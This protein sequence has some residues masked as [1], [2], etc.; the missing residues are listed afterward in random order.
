MAIIATTPFEAA[1]ASQQQLHVPPE[2]RLFTA[3]DPAPTRFNR[4]GYLGTVH[5]YVNLIAQAEEVAVQRREAA[6]AGGY[7]VKQHR[8]SE[9][10]KGVA[11]ELFARLAYQSAA[12]RGL[13]TFSELISDRPDQRPDL[14]FGV[15]PGLA[16]LLEAQQ[17]DVKTSCERIACLQPTRPD[18]YFLVA[19]HDLD[20]YGPEV[21]GCL[22]VHIV[23]K[24]QAHLAYA[25]CE[26]IRENWTRYERGEHPTAK[27]Y[28]AYARPIAGV[29]PGSVR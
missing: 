27:K 12:E 4:G 7:A 3:D 9:E 24:F 22:F 18:N 1:A 2:L 5:T 29:L 15:P 6:I 17:V 25:S 14:H 8:H 16:D 28:P 23:S 13:V 19:A 20:A 11:G 26:F 10:L 21:T